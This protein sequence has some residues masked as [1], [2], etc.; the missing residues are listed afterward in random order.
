M[1]ALMRNELGEM[2]PRFVIGGVTSGAEGLRQ[3]I[4]E[5]S[6]HSEFLVAENYL[7]PAHNETWRTNERNGMKK[8]PTRLFSPEQEKTHPHPPYLLVT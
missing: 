6:R 3:E 1:I 4:I 5:P 7:D 2:I 8:R